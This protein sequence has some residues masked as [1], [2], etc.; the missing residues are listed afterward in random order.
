MATRLALT[1][2]LTLTRTRT[3]TRTLTR[4]L[5]LALTLTTRL[6]LHLLGRVQ[7][8]LQGPGG[9]DGWRTFVNQE[10]P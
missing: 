7:A 3:L 8:M 10:V 4:A 9:L 5:A 1:P 6:A 2:T